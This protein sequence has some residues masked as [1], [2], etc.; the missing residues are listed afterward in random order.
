VVVLTALRTRICH[1]PP[2]YDSIAA[3]SLS[4]SDVV[5]SSWESPP[6]IHEAGP[7]RFPG[8]GSRATWNVF[9]RRAGGRTFFETRAGA[10][11]EGHG[12]HLKR[13]SSGLAKFV[14][15]PRYR[16]RES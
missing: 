15:G 13:Q 8:E 12:R 2:R 3:S 1:Y 11:V 10:R 5:A 4:R 9:D 14:Q 16:L 7:G 6:E